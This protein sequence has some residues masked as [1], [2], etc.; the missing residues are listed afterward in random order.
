ML[1]FHGDA[2]SVTSSAIVD[3]FIASFLNGS[4]SEH[5]AIWANVSPVIERSE[6]PV[7]AQESTGLF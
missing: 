3:Q 6:A 5:L 7:V 4:L 1:S 2:S